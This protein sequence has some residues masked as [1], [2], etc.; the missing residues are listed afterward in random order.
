MAI[1]KKLKELLDNEGI[2]YELLQ[3]PTTYTASETAGVQH[4]RGKDFVKSIILK[5]GDQ[6]LMCVLPAIHLID[7]GKLKSILN[8]NDISLATEEEVANLFPDYDVGA[9]PP[10]G[11][12]NTLPVYADKFLEEN[13]TIF[14]N[15]GTHTDMVK[16]NF[17]D[18]KK[19]AKPNFIDCST[20]V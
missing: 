19:L 6:F 11:I 5:S 3:H 15:G 2:K 20:H 1:A 9:E 10:I 17:Q 4:V 8:L 13:S 12:E 14:F 18:F 16:I 7:F